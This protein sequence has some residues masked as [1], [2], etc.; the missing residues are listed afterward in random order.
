[1]NPEELSETSF[2]QT[3]A[4]Q[5]GNQVSMVDDGNGPTACF[6]NREM[7]VTLKSSFL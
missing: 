7:H 6:I 4:G 3:V 5:S 1:M 2:I